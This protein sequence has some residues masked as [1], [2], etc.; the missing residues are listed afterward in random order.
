ME[1]CPAF[2]WCDRS[3]TAFRSADTALGEALLGAAAHRRL[4]LAGRAKIDDLGVAHGG[5]VACLGCGLG[6]LR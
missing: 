6:G 4:W 5:G 1:S 3:A 2:P